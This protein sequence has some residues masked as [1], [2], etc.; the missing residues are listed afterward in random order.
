VSRLLGVLSRLSILR[1]AVVGALGMPV[2]WVVLQLMVHWGSG[3]YVGRVLSWFCAA[4]FTWAGNRYFT[5]AASR[6]RGLLGTGK[7]WLRFLAA[8]AVGGLVNVGLYSV[9]VR[10]APPPFNNLTIALVCGVLLGLVFNFTLSKKVVFRSV[11][12]SRSNRYKGP[13]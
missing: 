4:S 9:L 11:G 5:F 1:F 10:F 2:D 13:L 3:P 7:E 12:A 6:A 8:N